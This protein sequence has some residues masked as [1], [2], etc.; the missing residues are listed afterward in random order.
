MSATTTSATQALQDRWNAAMMTNYGTPPI[1]LVRGSGAE[2]WDADGKRYLDLLAGIAVNALGHGHPAIVEA[3][4]TQLKTLGHTSNLYIT[5][6]GVA[7][8]ERL[9]GLLDATG[10]GRVFFANSGAEAN[11]CALKLARRYGAEHDLRDEVIACHDAFHGRTLGALAVTG[12]ADK[13]EPFSPLP[14]PVTFVSYGDIEALRNRASR[15]T[16][17]I[18]LE[19]TLGEAGVVTPPAGYLAAAREVCDE[20]GA[21][22]ILDEVQ[23]GIGRTGAWFAYQNEPVDIRPDVVTLAKG[24]GGGLPIGACVARTPV[25]AASLVRGQHGSTFGGNPVS[26]SAALAVLDT[27]VSD[28]LLAHVR[29]VGDELAAGITGLRHPLVERVEGIGL[30]RGIVLT[31]PV[32]GAFE[33]AARSAG[34]LVNPAAPTRVRLAPP[35]ILTSAQVAEFVAGLPALLDAADAAGSAA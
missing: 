3:V 23:G 4:T 1:A 32:S 10:T 13:R 5:E 27:I 35:L 19:P 25:A 7:L 28:G 8:A 31:K 33:T 21:L 17:A 29:R 20:V 9:L 6:P 14:G 34:F 24:L 11:E 15:R 16:A 26:T 2:V 30:W 22:L 12:S 18:I